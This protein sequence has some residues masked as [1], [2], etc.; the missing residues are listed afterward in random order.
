[1]EAENA[2]LRA[3]EEAQKPRTRKRVKEGANDK[4]ASIEAIA[5]AQEASLQPPKPRK[6]KKTADPP[7]NLEERVEEVIQV[8]HRF[9]E[10]EE[11]Q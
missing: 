8:F 9:R 4:F 1:M 3:S 7:P 5:E 6:R 11:M 2:R 10:A